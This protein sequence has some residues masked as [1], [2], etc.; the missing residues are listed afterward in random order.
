MKN[1]KRREMR[2]QPSSPI[3]ACSSCMITDLL[4][5][6][7]MASDLSV[8]VEEEDE[9]PWQALIHPIGM[10]DH[11]MLSIRNYELLTSKQGL[12]AF[13]TRRCPLGS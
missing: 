3:E 9:G 10:L 2:I 8:E 13:R 5:Q 1:T 12:A 7:R 4:H 6:A 11:D